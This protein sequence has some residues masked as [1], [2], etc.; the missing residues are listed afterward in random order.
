MRRRLLMAIAAVS[1][2][3]ATENIV[4]IVVSRFFTL[5][6]ELVTWTI[7]ALIAAVVVYI[8]GEDRG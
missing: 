3:F 1:G 8:I 5:H 4:D 6:A 7:V 2:V